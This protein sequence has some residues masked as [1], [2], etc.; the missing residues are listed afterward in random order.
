MPSPF[1]PSGPGRPGHRN[2]TGVLLPSSADWR[3]WAFVQVRLYDLPHD[4]T[5]A[6]IHRNFRGRGNVSQIQIYESRIGGQSSS[7][8]IT[9]KPPPAHAFWPASARFK[10]SDKI[11][12]RIRIRLSSHQKRNFT[13][14]SPIREVSYPEEIVLK[15]LSLDFGILGKEKEMTVFN[16]VSSHSESLP[17]SMA[18]PPSLVI[19]LRKREIEVHFPILLDSASRTGARIRHYRFPVSFDESPQIWKLEDN[20]RAGISYIIHVRNPPWYSRR[21]ETALSASHVKDAKTWREDDLWTRQTD[22]VVHKSTFDAINATPVTLRKNL[23]RVNIARWTTFKFNLDSGKQDHPTLNLFESALHDFNVQVNL[24]TNDLT[25]T[26]KLDKDYA[27]YWSD[28][29][30]SGDPEDV[31]DTGCTLSFGLR[32]QLEVCISNGWLSEYAIDKAFLRKL[33]ELPETKGK[34]MLIH[35]DTFAEEIRDPMVI[36]SD[37]RY[38]KPVRARQLP[39]SCT[40]VYHAT[41]TATGLKAHTPTV[42][43]S[44]RITREYKRHADRFLRVKFEDDEYRGQSRIFSSS[45]KKMQLVIDRV[46]RALSSGIVIAGVH[47]KFLAYGNSQLREHGAYFFAKTPDLS[48]STIRA[49]MGAFDNEKIVAKRAAR[50]GQCFSTTHPI[51]CRL[52]P[53]DMIPDIRYN[54]HIFTDGVGKISPLAAALVQGSL[55]VPGRTPSCFQFRLGGCK[56]VLVVDPSLSGPSLQIRPSQ[57][58]F[59]S[60]SQELEIIRYSQFWQP[61][62]NRQI[63][64]VL[65][66]LGVSDEIFLAM[67]KSTIQALGKAMHD[68]DAALSALRTHVDPNLMTLSMCDLISHGFRRVQ[69]P[70]VTSL[71]QLWRAYSLKYLKEKAKIP[72][73][74]GAFVLGAV[75]ETNTLRGHFNELQPPQ[76]ADRREKEKALPEIFLQITDTGTGMPRVIEGICILARNPSLH[77]GDIRVVKAVD[78]IKLRHICDVVLMPQNG[79]RDLPSMCSGGDLDGDDYIVIWD[80]RLIPTTWNEE[81]FHYIPPIPV[82]A[83]GEITTKHI[84]DFFLHYLTNDQL[85]RIAHAHLGAA[86]WYDDGVKNEA[87]LEL[88]QLHSTSVDYPKTGVPAE[89]PRHLERNKWPHFMEKRSKSYHSE[90]IL[91]QLYDDVKKSVKRFDFTARYNLKFDRR[92]LE[93]DRPDKSFFVV[94]ETLK[95]EYDMAMQRIMAQHKIET[96]F[97][98]W[99]TFVMGHSKQSRDFKFHEEIGRISKSLKDEHRA[100]LVRNA[101]GSDFDRLM[102]Y[103]VAAYQLTADQITTTL[104]TGGEDAIDLAETLEEEEA[105]EGTVLSKRKIPFCSF[106]WLLS[107]VLGKIA[108]TSNVG[109]EPSRSVDATK[110]SDKAAALEEKVKVFRRDSKTYEHKASPKKSG[111]LTSSNASL[112]AFSEL[113][114]FSSKRLEGSSSRKASLTPARDQDEL[115]KPAIKAKDVKTMQPVLAH[116]SKAQFPVKRPEVN[117]IG[118]ASDSDSLN[119]LPSAISSS[120]SSLIERD[121]SIEQSSAVNGTSTSV[122]TAKGVLGDPALMSAEE[123]ARLFEDEDDL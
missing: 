72:V 30:Y 115:S 8:E 10:T 67:Q 58:K 3:T 122:F 51:R 47:Y 100:E 105:E 123:K 70:F 91:G 99:S 34:Q 68:D 32:Y 11:E 95:H 54:D 9:F 85:G 75:D 44:N 119:D 109:E 111:G 87:C 36:F 107:D 97:E 80:E 20:A 60:K 24:N 46:G 76:Q 22:I 62:L 33:K 6:D 53:I 104:S 40:L 39:D 81:P 4:V 43:V 42:E 56:G 114:P 65:S 86:D 83:Q 16:S 59:E 12:A 19:N 69:E 71:L 118:N 29:D 66:H 88:I 49:E 50:M 55:G 113:D 96:E 90:K 94:V 74:D 41:V 98:V 106:P 5:T 117:V 89:L 45:N 61:F 79:D 18:S 77:P 13:V 26:E 93:L 102:P 52:L 63:I 28:I 14:R 38:Q 25:V 92:I 15:G 78:C 108:S 64:L 7:A 48:A 112:H 73:K 110:A 23:N 31:F 120:G 37:I 1:S 27:T 57:F 101:G 17:E 84:I 116:R 21:L 121:A 82:T 35:V 103:A 2:S